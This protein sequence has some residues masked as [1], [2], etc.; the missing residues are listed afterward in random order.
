MTNSFSDFFQ[1]TNV[2]NFSIKIRC[3]KICLEA[4]KIMQPGRNT[5][6]KQQICKKKKQEDIY[7]TAINMNDY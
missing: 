6:K 1:D 4:A 2:L 5:R 3:H 7:S